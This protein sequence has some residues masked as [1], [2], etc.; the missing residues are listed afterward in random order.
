MALVAQHANKMA[1]VGV[2]GLTCND[3]VMVCDREWVHVAIRGL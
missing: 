3:E 1:I 2:A